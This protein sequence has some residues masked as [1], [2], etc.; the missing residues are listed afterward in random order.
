LIHDGDIIQATAPN[1]QHIDV[2]HF[3]F[4]CVVIFYP[5]FGLDPVFNGTFDA[6]RFQF[7]QITKALSLWPI[8]YRYS[9]IFIFNCVSLLLWERLPAAINRG[10]TAQMRYS[11]LEAAPTR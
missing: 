3:V 1:D 7:S 9:D 2:V 4:L 5:P 11:R 10:S 6:C 8:S